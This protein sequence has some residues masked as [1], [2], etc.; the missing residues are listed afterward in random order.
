MRCLSFILSN[1]VCSWMLIV[2]LLQH[3]IWYVVNAKVIEYTFVWPRFPYVT[4]LGP[5]N[6]WRNNRVFQRKVWFDVAKTH[7]ILLYL[8]PV[9]L[10]RYDFVKNLF[11]V[12]FFLMANAWISQFV[13]QWFKIF[14]LGFVER[15]RYV[16]FIQ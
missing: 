14:D 13:K 9:N 2:I 12:S 16:S 5:Y 7:W 10:W 8:F 3:L 11:I 1:A 4:W 15:Y 6:G